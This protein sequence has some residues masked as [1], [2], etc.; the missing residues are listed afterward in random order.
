MAFGAASRPSFRDHG[1]QVIQNARAPVD[2]VMVGGQGIVSGGTD[3]HR[4]LVDPYP[5]G[6]TRKLADI[7]LI[8][9]G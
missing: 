9:W 5:K 1:A 3:R 8:A 6:V 4:V 7:A 2:V